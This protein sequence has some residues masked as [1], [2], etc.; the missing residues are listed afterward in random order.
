MF[1]T[2]SE[3]DRVLIFRFSLSVMMA[4]MSLLA[5]FVGK[6][7]KEKTMNY[8]VY[9]Y[10][11]CCGILLGEGF[12]DIFFVQVIQPK[13]A[14]ITFSVAFLVFYSAKSFNPQ[15]QYEYNQVSN[16]E[17]GMGEDDENLGI[18]ISDNIPE[19]LQQEAFEDDLELNHGSQHRKISSFQKL[20][21]IWFFFMA[22]SIC[23]NEVSKGL[24]LGSET[25]HGLFGYEEVIFDGILHALAF[26][27]LCEETLHSSS[28]YLSAIFLF[29]AAKPI[30]VVIGNFLLYDS[31]Y[32]VCAW[33]A[34]LT[35]GVYLSFVVFYMI[36]MDENLN[37]NTMNSSR[38]SKE[39]L[40]KN[41]RLR[42][43]ALILGYSLT[44]ITQFL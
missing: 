5:C 31:I 24:V 41:A 10:S 12:I 28:A 38:S 13:V 19:F 16:L 22:L 34:L 33:I 23:G 44:L 6:F 21:F 2:V 20:S 36:P 1:D 4:S 42:M 25:H 37:E 32:T 3:K 7:V 39:E 43:T 14:A 26:G 30:G 8:Y 15:S 35:S 18:E 40:N 17:M 9:F 27:V 29:I 11:L